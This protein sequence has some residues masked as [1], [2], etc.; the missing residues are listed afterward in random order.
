VIFAADVYSDRRYSMETA[1]TA[2]ITQTIA[3]PEF[4][5]PVS[6]ISVLGVGSDGITTFLYLEVDSAEHSTTS[7]RSFLRANVAELKCYST[8]GRQWGSL[9]GR[10]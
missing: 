10:Q 7:G 5:I 1:A 8:C 2:Q 9:G 3:V 6:S 4:G